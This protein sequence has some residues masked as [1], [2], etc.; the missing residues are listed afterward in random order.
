MAEISRDIPS[1]LLPLAPEPGESLMGLVSRVAAR[2]MHGTVAHILAAAKYPHHAHFDMAISRPERLTDLARVL[3][4]TKADLVERF[5]EPVPTPYRTIRVDFFGTNV[6]AC[7]LDFRARR[8]CPRTLR[9]TPH[10]R[11]IW[12][13]RL[14]PWC[15]ET[16]GLV[17]ERCPACAADLR[18][19]RAEGV[20]VCDACKEDLRQFDSTFD[21]GLRH[22]VDPLLDLISPDPARYEPA[23]LRLHPDVRDIGRGAAFELGWTLACAFG[24]PAGETPRQR[25]S[26]LPRDTIVD[27]LVQAAD[28]LTAWPGCIEDLLAS[29]GRSNDAITLDRTVRRLRADF[30]PRRSW[31]ELSELVVKA[32]PSIFTWSVRSRGVVH[33]FAP[34]L[35]GGQEAIRL[36]GMG[37]RK[38]TH[39]YR[40]GLVDQIVRSGGERHA[41]AT[42]DATSLTAASEVFRDRMRVTAAAEKLGTTYHGIEQLICLEVLEEITDARVLAVSLGRQ[43]SRSGFEELE[44]DIRRAAVASG[45]GWV[46]AY[47]ALKAMGSA[48]K[49]YGPLLVAMRDRL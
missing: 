23:I 39:L 14:V 20:A 47:D 17:I 28:L 45:D 3:G 37:S 44:A 12:N 40:S 2:N 35:V 22:I 27:T 43:I 33:D 16:G 5:H 48:E 7:D 32:H 19:H 29:F 9:E 8:I 24:G 15:T 25:Q 34:G 42:Y 1:V 13:H 10:H 21:E 31:P 36:L 49:P 30:R 38:F 18:W 4:V 41:F 11:A 46:P 26:K 6:M